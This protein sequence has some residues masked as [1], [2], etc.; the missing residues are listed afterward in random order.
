[1]NTQPLEHEQYDQLL[2][3]FVNGTLNDDERTAVERHV[4][5]CAECRESVRVLEAAERTIRHPS[6]AP[7]VP[8]ANAEA[9]F[10]AIDSDVPDV[11]SRTS[12]RWL[13]AAAIV[14]AA[15]LLTLGLLP[16]TPDPTDA[17]S[18]EF[19]T[20]T[21]ASTVD[22]T[23]YVFEIRLADVASE[24]E[25]QKVLSEL[26]ART[27]G[28]PGTDGAVE[29]VIPLEAKSMTEL[30][31]FEKSLSSRESIESAHLIAI[32]LPLD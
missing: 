24:D 14:G 1:M 8:E 11:S 16:G 30:Q 3:W 28:E 18:T 10:A 21:S 23:D 6:P 4:A 19:R 5:D 31:D 20:A 2:P 32:Q 13:L 7:L 27:R 25:W 26:N 12:L 9:L 22:L 29:V 15:A 17:P